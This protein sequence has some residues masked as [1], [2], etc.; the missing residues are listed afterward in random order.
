MEQNL[1]D[2]Y[3]F[4]MQIWFSS[5]NYITGYNFI[6]ITLLDEQNRSIYFTNRKMIIFEMQC[7]LQKG[8]INMCFISIFIISICEAWN[9]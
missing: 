7:L 5:P 6:I 1:L 2:P 8:K 3:N 4:K 9:P